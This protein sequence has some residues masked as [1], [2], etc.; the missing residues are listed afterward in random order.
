MAVVRKR[1]AKPREEHVRDMGS[2]T[3]LVDELQK[4]GLHDFP[5]HVERVAEF[6]GLEVAEEL[7]DSDVSGYLEFKGGRWVAGINA[8]HHRN[9]QRFTLAHE[10]AH[11]V[12]HRNERARFVD[13]TFARREGGGDAVE[14]QADRFA[15]ELLMPEA[16]VR[17]MIGQGTTSL[18]ELA[19]HFHVSVL[20]MRFRVKNL[21]YQVR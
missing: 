3:G 18:K 12:L 7:M 10:I 9:R 6:L 19:S 4:E 13:Q 11:F 2:L 14:S 17:E 20:A 16:K 5:L 21:G 1:E 15:A 8:L